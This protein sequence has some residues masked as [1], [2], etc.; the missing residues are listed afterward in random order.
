MLFY[1]YYQYLLFCYFGLIDV[2]YTPS[3]SASIITVVR[4]MRVAVVYQQLLQMGEISLPFIL[5]D[6]LIIRTGDFGVLGTV[7]GKRRRKFWLEFNITD[8]TCFYVPPNMGAILV[9]S[10]GMSVQSCPPGV[11]AKRALRTQ[12]RQI[13]IVT[14]AGA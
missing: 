13:N 12:I 8:R 10:V 3:P 2:I 4:K 1:C 14:L 5:T 7:S 9:F 11:L 6:M